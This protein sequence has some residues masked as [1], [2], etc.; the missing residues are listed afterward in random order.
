MCKKRG[1]RC[2]YGEE[3]ITHVLCTTPATWM[4]V[5]VC[6][7]REV[8]RKAGSGGLGVDTGHVRAGKM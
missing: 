6:C 5:G 4:V 3:L 2:R 7:T 8:R 1:K